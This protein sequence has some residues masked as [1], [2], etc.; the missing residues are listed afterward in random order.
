MGQVVSDKM[1]KTV[2]V[3]VETLKHHP[4]YKKTIRHTKKYM[5][6]DKHNACKIGDTVKILETHPLSKRKR[7]LVVGV[8]S[9]REVAVLNSMKDQPE[10]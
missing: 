7:W 5:V 6:H 10:E 3:S 2:V 1:D 9:R 4:L 8:I